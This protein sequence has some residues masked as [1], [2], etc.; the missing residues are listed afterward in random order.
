MSSKKKSWVQFHP[1]IKGS[2]IVDIVRYSDSEKLLDQLLMGLDSEDFSIVLN[3]PE[4]IE[5]EY[6]GKPHSYFVPEN[7]AN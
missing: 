3:T 4:R 1:T 2:A 6:E 5:L 7:H